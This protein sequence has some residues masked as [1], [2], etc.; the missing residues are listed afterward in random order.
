MSK[1]ED[2]V[3]FGKTH[4]CLNMKILLYLEGHTCV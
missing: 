4:M 1:Y 3:I 2:I